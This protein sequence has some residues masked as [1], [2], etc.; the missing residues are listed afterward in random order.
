[1]PRDLHA[2]QQLPGIGPY[3]A[4]AWLGFHGGKRAVIIDANVVRLLSRILGRPYDGETRRRTWL[5]QVA[6]VLTP[7]RAWKPYNYAVLDF[8]MQI[9]SKNPNCARCPLLSVPCA[10]GARVVARGTT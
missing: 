6:D 2:L 7:I 9:C 10:H 3:A 8:A 5:L 1:M 4:A